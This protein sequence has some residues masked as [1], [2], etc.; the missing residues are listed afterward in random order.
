MIPVGGMQYYSIRAASFP[1]VDLSHVRRVTMSHSGYNTSGTWFEITIAPPE[2]ANGAAEVAKTSEPRP[3]QAPVGAAAAATLLGLGLSRPLANLTGKVGPSEEEIV[4]KEAISQHVSTKTVS[5]IDEIT[6][7]LW[8]AGTDGLPKEEAKA[9]L[10]KLAPVIRSTVKERD[11]AYDALI[12]EAYAI[13]LAMSMSVPGKY[14]QPDRSE[15]QALAAI[16]KDMDIEVYMPISQLPPEAAKRF[17]VPV[18]NIFGDRLRTYQTAEDLSRMI[19]NPVKAVVMSVDLKGEDM[20]LLGRTMGME[21]LAKTRIL[22]F[23]KTD[24]NEMNDDEYTNYIA[25]TLSILLAGRALTEET[26]RDRSSA[27]YRVF[28]HLLE[29]HMSDI[30]QIDTYIRNVADGSMDP[31][32]KLAYLLKNI[33][34]TIPVTAYSIMKPAVE[35]LWSA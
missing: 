22:P 15:I 11:A 35:V 9:R 23:E 3:A 28:A 31:I 20:S 19:K 24:I 2:A 27:P 34:K 4:E 16:I 17:R 8:Q 12:R 25:E 5:R 33:L 30:G 14:K 21:A 32:K 6:D 26:A 13:L 1:G 29:C 18:E 10:A 7:V